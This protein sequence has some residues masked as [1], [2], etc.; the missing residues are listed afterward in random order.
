VSRLILAIDP[1]RVSGLALVRPGGRGEAPTLLGAWVVTAS[2][3]RAWLRRA[4]A[5]LDEA[6]ALS[7]LPWRV[8][9]EK[10][11]PARRMRG[12]A[13]GAGGDKQGIATASGMGKYRGYLI[14]LAHRRSPDHEPKMIPVRDW[15]KGLNVRA[16]KRGDGSHRLTEMRTLMQ[17]ACA[18]PT[19]VDAAEAALVGCWAALA[20]QAD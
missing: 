1:G 20:E 16:G 7:A 11:P 8:V 19:T 2:T 18:W 6:Q 9:A 15:T 17:A 3:Q 5:A 12:G 10:D 4:D 13:R 14:A